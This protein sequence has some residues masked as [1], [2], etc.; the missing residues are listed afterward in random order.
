MENTI[1]IKKIFSRHIA[2]TLGMLEA[3]SIHPQI[4]QA[5]KAEFWFTAEDVL[6]YLS[7]REGAIENGDGSGK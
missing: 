1:D 7:E 2:K 6:S 4:K 3:S 5:I